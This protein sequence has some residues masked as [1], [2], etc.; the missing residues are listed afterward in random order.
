MIATKRHKIHK[1]LSKG[2]LCCLCL[3]VALSFV[4]AFLPLAASA[5]NSNSMPCCA[6]K[7]GHCDSGIIAKKAQRPQEPMCGLRREVENDGI[8]IVAE[9]SQN[10]PHHASQSSS[11]GSEFASLRRACRMECGVC[12]AG[13]SRQQSRERALS[14]VDSRDLSTFA[15]HSHRQYQPPFFSS[16]DEWSRIIP[17]GPPVSSIE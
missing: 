10:Q 15:T 6:G 14:Q 11:T 3:L 16:S 17:R 1:L 12:T 13:S 5:N 7:S 4:A 8:T 9:P 2:S